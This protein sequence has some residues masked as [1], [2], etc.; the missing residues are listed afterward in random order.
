VDKTL[1]SILG[2][3]AIARATTP[4]R[5]ALLPVSNNTRFP[6]NSNIFLSL[7]K[8]RLNSEAPGKVIFL[9]RDKIEAVQAERELKRQGA[10]EGN[11]SRMTRAP[12]GADF[13]L[14]ASFDGMSQA[15]AGA[16]SDYILYTYKLIDTETDEEVFEEYEQIKKEGMDNVI[17]R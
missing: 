4:P 6:V 12:K 3:P 15:S 9:S 13:F 5:I 2:T 10:V 1:R 16:T 14:T 11:P 8:A 17:Y 7:L